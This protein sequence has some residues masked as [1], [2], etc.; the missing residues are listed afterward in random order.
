M[1]VV[2]SLQTTHGG[3]IKVKFLANDQGYG[4]ASLQSGHG[5]RFG[6]STMIF[7]GE[8]TLEFVPS[9]WL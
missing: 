8:G 7:N 4:L 6:Y 2:L 1:S 9:F 5:G 3:H